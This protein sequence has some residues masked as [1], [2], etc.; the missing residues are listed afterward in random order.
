MAGLLE[1]VVAG[2]TIVDQGARPIDTDNTLQRHRG[3]LRVD[4]IASDAI[5]TD[6]GMKPDRVTADPP[7]GFIRGNDLGLLEMLLDFLVGRLQSL[8]GPQHDLRRSATAE[9]DAEQG[10]KHVRDFAVRQ[11]SAFVEIDDSRLG[12]GAH[13]AGSGT[14]GI[15]RLQRMPALAVA[16]TVPAFAEVDVELPHDRSAR[17]LF[18]ILGLDVRFVDRAAT[19]RTGVGQRRFQDF[20]N[21]LGRRSMAMLAVLATGLASWL[22][23]VLLGWAPRERRRLAFAGTLI[24]FQQPPKPI[25]FGVALP[26]DG[27][28]L[29][30]S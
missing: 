13:L 4:V 17:D 23:R 9:V 21:V 11:A 24:L 2:P 29:G 20:I 15:R 18:L 16:A 22:F 30:Q 10:S 25:D 8:A 1:L 5:G 27:L 12:V 3:T 28:Q 26:H 7:A 6:P 14:H 19:V